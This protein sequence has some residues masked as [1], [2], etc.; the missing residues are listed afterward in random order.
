[1]GGNPTLEEF[2]KKFSSL[3]F[4]VLYH[5]FPQDAERES[6]WDLLLEQPHAKSNQL[7]TFEVSTPPQEW[8]KPTSAKRLHDHRSLYLE[9]EGPIS[10]NRGFVSQVL[11]GEAQWVTRTDK[12]LALNVQFRWEKEQQSPLVMATLNLTK[13]DTENDLA[14]ELKLQIP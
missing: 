11:K 9:Y 13:T 6:H 8:R 10:G 5:Q 1:M 14:W 2:G 3:Q 7:L 4:V 12:L